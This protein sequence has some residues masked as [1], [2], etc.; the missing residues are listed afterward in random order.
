MHITRDVMWFTL[1]VLQT[2]PDFLRIGISKDLMTKA[3]DIKTYARAIQ[4]L[5]I[6]YTKLE[7]AV[8]VKVKVE[9]QEVLHHLVQTVQ[10]VCYNDMKTTM[11]WTQL[12]ADENSM[13]SNFSLEDA[14]DLT[15]N[16]TVELRLIVQ[17]RRQTAA[18]HYQMHSIQ[19]A[20]IED[21]EPEEGDEELQKKILQHVAWAMLLRK[22]APRTRPHL[23]GPLSC[24]RH[25]T[26]T[27]DAQMV[28][29]V[30]W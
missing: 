7:V 28:E 16:F 27:K 6:F 21:E 17:R 4:W 23:N 20:A 15:R 5:E 13:T 3:S 1:K 12:A 9:P 2:S 10:H 8:E 22:E 26:V 18:V 14:L 29:T 30:I 11:I 25:T 19:S 24:A